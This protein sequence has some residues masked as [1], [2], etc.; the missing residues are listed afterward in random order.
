MRQSGGKLYTLRAGANGL[1]E[2]LCAQL[3]C[4][5][6]SPDGAPGGGLF[7]TRL[8][9]L[10]HKLTYQINQN[11]NLNASA[12]IRLKYQPFRGGS[13]GNAKFQTPETTQKQESWF[14]IFK[15]QWV[16][17]LSNRA[18][19]DVSLNNFG[20]YWVN[21]ANT[22]GTSFQDR[23]SSGVL[24]TF[25]QGP[26]NQ[27]LNN[28]RRWTEDIVFSYFFNGLGSHNLKTAYGFLWEDYR[29][30]TRGYPGHI[31]YVFNNGVPDR[32]IIQNTPVQ[33]QQNSLL[34][35]SFYV[36]D[37]WQVGRK[38]TMNLGLRFDRY[39]SY[40]P[41]MVRESAGSN[42]WA[43]QAT[44]YSNLAPGLAS[45]VD[46]HWDKQTVATFNKPVPRFSLIYDVFGNGKTAIKASYGL[47][48][49]NPS[50][51]LADE[52][53]DN[54]YR[55][56]TYNWNGTLPMSE[57]AHLSAC[58]TSGGCS[59]QSA[60]NLTQTRIDPNLKLPMTHEYTVGI[61]QQL[62]AD[63]GLRFNFVRKIQ[64]GAYDTINENYSMGDYTPFQF[65]DIGENG[66]AGDADDQILTFY[67]RN[68]AT[69][70]D[71]NLLTYR[72]GAGDMSRTFEI[73][74]VKRMSHRW[75]FIAGAD[76]TKRDLAASLF[77]TNPNTIIFENLSPGNHYWDWTTK[78]IG[79]YEFPK[80]V[81]F[82][83]SFR[84]QKGE[85]SI[86]TIALNCTVVINP[87][88]TCATAGGA[89]LRQGNVTAQTVARGGVE[90][91]FYPT[92]TLLDM[93]VRKTFPINERWGR[94]EANLDFFN[95]LN[96][97]TVRSWNTSS[98]STK[99]LK[100]NTVAANFH[101]PT[102]VLPA[103]VFRL[104]INYKF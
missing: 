52:A 96:A 20:Y 24:Q 37:K 55:T 6:D 49:W 103:R 12:N 57:P 28:N 77:S 23:S 46:Q 92:Q 86:R 102:N 16:S 1:A 34:D 104:G 22:T 31:R 26:Y 8:T 2:G 93:G 48:A 60:P 78:L 14:H 58:V 59:L 75:Q 43:S 25:I 13:G 42:V 99:T 76:W 29:G 87:G 82:N 74:G 61:D 17:T 9:N 36:Q 41:E 83:T 47:F 10:T 85:S 100:D 35:N 3:P 68:V 40:I 79:S 33:W 38:L 62:V 94:I 4:L 71:D 67:N 53:L 89:S 90:S 21:L 66:V 19:L 84:S 80:G 81:L 15:V 91:N 30:S 97:N 32:V 63:L 51:E 65:R 11:N 50:F 64:R 95:M 72:D 45:F 54:N 44:V 56:A 70:P 18:T 88:Q 73:E 27:D 7:F 101:L 69:R 5:T 39:T 98:S